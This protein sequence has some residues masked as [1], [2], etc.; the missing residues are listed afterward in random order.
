MTV[1]AAAAKA[2]PYTGNG[3]ASSFAFS[4]KVF[5][6]ADIRVVKTV[7]A[8]GVESD[9]VL[10][11]DYTVTRNV[12]QDTNPGGSVTYK[13]GGVATALPST[14]KLTIVG[15]F[16]YTQP[17]DIPNGG[18]FFASVIETAFDRVTLLVKQLKETLDRGLRVPVSDDTPAELPSAVERASKYLAF[19]ADGEPIATSGP[20]SGVPVSTFA[21]TL[22]DDTT[23]AAMRTTIGARSEADDVTLAAGKGVVFEG[24]TDDVFEGTLTGGDPTA[25]RTWTLPNKSGTVAMTS[26]VMTT[27]TGTQVRTTFT[28]SGNLTIPAGVTQAIVTGQAPGG[29]GGGSTDGTDGGTLTF[30]PNGGA[31]VLTLAGGLKGAAYSGGTAGAGGAGGGAGLNQGGAGAAGQTKNAIGGGVNPAGYAVALGGAGGAG[32]FGNLGGGGRGSDGPANL[33]EAS[34]G[35]GGA[36]EQTFRQVI[37]VTAGQWDVTIGSVG[38]AGTTSGSGTASSAGKGGFFIVEY[39][40]IALT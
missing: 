16:D 3:S 20:A 6:D 26:D 38:A 17:T 36:G 19:D 39:N 33:T 13:V 2:G 15:D 34:A 24:T 22:L 10:N 9:L 1:A 25:D 35:G 8:T 27:A 5:A 12:D 4:F 14:L 21:E 11:T 28:A 7:I 31:V 30:G 23:A 29:G 32:M 40:T 18:S 37:T